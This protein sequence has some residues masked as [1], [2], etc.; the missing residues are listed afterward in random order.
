MKYQITLRFTEPLLGTVPLD[1]EVYT[2]YIAAKKAELSPDEL[3]EELDTIHEEKSRTGF[4]TLE[5]GT[6]ILYDYVLKGFFKDACR[7]LRRVPG[8]QSKKLTAFLKIIDGLLFV[9]PRQIPIVLSGGMSVLERP[10]RA[11][12]AQGPRIA[13][14]A[15][16]SIPVGSTLE[17]V[18]SVLG[19][20]VDEDLLREWLD[21]GALRG[22]GQWRNASYGRFE[23]ELI[24]LD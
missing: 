6:P 14:T 21:Y 11:E 2:S 15:S 5:D 23:Y 19:K 18:V 20:D 24:V 10:L 17:F 1:K 22:L 3:N 16:D 9:T 12:T 4:H 13:L 7:M 8:T